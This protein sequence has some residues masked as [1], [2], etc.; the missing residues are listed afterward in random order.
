M[1]CGGLDGALFMA[2]DVDAV[3]SE[4]ASGFSEGMG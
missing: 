2:W 1:A 3:R 4:G